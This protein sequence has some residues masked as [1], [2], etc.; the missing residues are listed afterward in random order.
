MKKMRMSSIFDFSISK[1]G[2]IKI[3]MKISEKNE[4][5]KFFNYFTI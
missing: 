3:F 2:Y 1:L 4:M 5:K